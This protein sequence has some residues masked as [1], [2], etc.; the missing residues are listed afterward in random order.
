MRHYRQKTVPPKGGKNDIS[1]LINQALCFSLLLQSSGIAQALPLAPKKNLVT[2][3]E[4]E[5]ARPRSAD[6]DLGKPAGAWS[7]AGEA[8]SALERWL[9]A[10]SHLSPFGGTLWPD[11]LSTTDEDAPLRGAQAGGILPLP[12]S[13]PYRCG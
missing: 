10:A 6:P 11:A 12:A 2:K 4:L 9:D 7:V 8:G 3:S 1:W 5:T 13:C